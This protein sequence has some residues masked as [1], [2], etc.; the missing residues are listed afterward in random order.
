VV[1]PNVAACTDT[2]LP[3]E[4]TRLPRTQTE[5]DIP[6]I[7]IATGAYDPFDCTLRKIGIAES[8]FTASSGNGR[9]NLWPYNGHQPATGTAPG[10][11]ELMGSLDNLSRYDLVILPCDN[12]AL[13]EKA[14][15]D[16]LIAYSGRG[17]RVFM[18][19]LSYSWLRSDTT[20]NDTVNWMP[21]GQV[22]GT[23]FITLVDQTFPKGMAFASW[24]SAIG[25]ARP[26]AR[27]GAHS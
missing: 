7:A 4:L 13:K 16:N 8:E 21:G 3:D 22:E 9:V 27:A 14:L 1:I 2:R 20:F 12:R 6:A 15:E 5:G 23:D 11:D 25:A 18:T 24:L 19:D 26:V 10:G 17:G